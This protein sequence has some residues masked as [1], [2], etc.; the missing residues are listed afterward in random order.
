[1][2]TRPGHVARRE[3][4]A[5]RRGRDG[6]GGNQPALPEPAPRRGGVVAPSGQ[7]QGPHQERITRPIAGP[8]SRGGWCLLRAV[9]APSARAVCAPS[10]LRLRVVYALCSR[11]YTRAPRREARNTRNTKKQHSTP[12]VFP[13]IFSRLLA[14]P[15]VFSRPPVSCVCW[16]RLFVCVGYGCVAPSYCGFALDWPSPTKRP[17]RSSICRITSHPPDKERFFVITFFFV[18]GTSTDKKAGILKFAQAPPGNA[19]FCSSAGRGK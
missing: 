15:R 12:V 2:L 7:R 17:I 18:A 6:G 9:Y 1:M 5:G 10:T 3:R 16:F 11:H 4:S 19:A 13:R 14:S 8:M